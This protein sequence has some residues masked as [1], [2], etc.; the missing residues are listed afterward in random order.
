MEL[1]VKIP[2]HEQLKKDLVS[3]FTPQSTYLGNHVRQVLMESD[4]KVLKQNS[5]PPQYIKKGDVI[6]LPQGSKNRP[7]VVAKVLKDRTVV[8]IA[9]TSTENIHCQTP[10]TSRFFGE[11]CFCKGF[12]ICTEEKAIQ[13]FIGT[14][15]NTKALNQA[16]KDLKE[17]VAE[18]I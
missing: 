3:K 15:D 12:D 2:P 13:N 8:M 18:T 9:L 11:G 6:V 7:N 14:F 17:F 5:H 4:F 1:E 10:Y 16:I